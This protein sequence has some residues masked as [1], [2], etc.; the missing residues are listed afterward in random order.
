M[1]PHLS[2]VIPALNEGARIGQAIQ[3]TCAYL[4]R[5]PYA[6]ELLVVDDGSRD[7]TPQRVEALIQQNHR[8]RLIRHAKNLGKGAAVRTGLQNAQGNLILFCDADGATPIE[9][10]DRFLPACR[11]G[12]CLVCASRHLPGSCVHAHQSVW[13]R[14]LSSGYR[15]L[16]R[17]CVTPGVTDVTCGFKLLSREAAA[18]LLPRMRVDGWSF[19]AEMLTIARI[20]GL[21][22]VELPIAWS[23]QGKSKVR[24]KRDVLA[25]FWELVQI[26]FRRLMGRYR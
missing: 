6:W 3:T 8:L 16:C 20:H 17:L 4:D 15:W 14:F 22:H 1:R 18:I 5:Q 26:L 7:G 2:V 24:L 21:R 13:R 25:S 10:L 9:E 11:D 12:T 19:D 23:D